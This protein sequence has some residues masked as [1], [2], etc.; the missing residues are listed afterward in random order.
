SIT[1][2]TP[3]SGTVGSTVVLTGKNLQHVAGVSFGGPLGAITAQPADGLS[4]S[5]TVPAGANYG[6]LGLISEKGVVGSAVTFAPVETPVIASVSPLG[7]QKAG[8]V[9][10]ITGS[11]FTAVDTVKLG[12]TSLTSVKVTDAKI[13]ATIPLGTAAGPYDLSV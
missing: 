4:L 8:A 12:T 9:I 7:G 3:A 10:T 13:T 11:H 5:V 2:A 1:K 6:K